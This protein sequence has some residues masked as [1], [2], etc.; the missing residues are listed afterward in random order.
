MSTDPYDDEADEILFINSSGEVFR[1]SVY[2]GE[3]ISEVSDGCMPFRSPSTEKYGYV[4]KNGRIIIEPNL[5]FG[6]GFV[7]RLADFA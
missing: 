6:G 7:G 5:G 2:S 4:D 3:G 1:T